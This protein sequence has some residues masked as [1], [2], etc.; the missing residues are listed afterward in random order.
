M[1]VMLV[2]TLMTE[3]GGR[4]GGKKLAQLM[5]HETVCDNHALYMDSCMV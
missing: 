5:D 1:L 2:L 3:K 4:G